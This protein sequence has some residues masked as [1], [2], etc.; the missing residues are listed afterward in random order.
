MVTAAATHHWLT[1]GPTLHQIDLGGDGRPV[2]CIH[3]VASCGWV[4]HHTAPH[5]AAVGRVV[6]VDLRGHGLSD[7]A[8]DGRYS[9]AGHATDV[10]AVIRSMSTGAVDL[11]GSSWGALVALAVAASRPGLVRRLILVDIEPS[12]EQPETA[13][14]ERPGSFATLDE[15]AALWRTLN[16]HAPQDLVELLAAASTRPDRRGTRAVLH[17]PVFLERWPFRS[18]DWWDALDAVE[19]PTLVVHAEHTWV[20]GEVCDR[21]AERLTD[22][23]RIDI[24]DSAHV[25]PVDRPTELGRALARF[26][27][28]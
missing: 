21:M 1:E 14:P 10:E 12:S 3:G 16:P 22:A 6:A 17:D 7:W 11:V 15:A 5:L 9:T 8:A 28:V 24:A 25:I 23:E 4:W 26:L 20:R 2:L 18:E 19:A 27:G 13:V